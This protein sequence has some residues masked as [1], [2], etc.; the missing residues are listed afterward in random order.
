[1]RTRQVA[2]GG[3]HSKATLS[4]ALEAA[5]SRRR[6]LIRRNAKRRPRRPY[7]IEANSILPTTLPH[8]PRNYALAQRTRPDWRSAPLR[9]KFRDFAGRGRLRAKSLAGDSRDD[10]PK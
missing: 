2:P 6:K 7:G 5:F 8:A 4:V 1:L 9:D 10:R 3:S